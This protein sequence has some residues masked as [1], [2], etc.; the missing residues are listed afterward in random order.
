[1]PWQFK[2]AHTFAISYF[3]WCITIINVSI[4]LYVLA[5]CVCVRARL[6]L[7]SCGF[8]DLN[9]LRLCKY[10]STLAPWY[11]FCS[12][13]IPYRYYYYFHFTSAN[14]TKRKPTR[15]CKKK[16]HSWQLAFRWVSQFNS[17]GISAMREHRNV[18]YKWYFARKLYNR[19]L[20]TIFIIIQILIDVTSSKRI[21]HGS[22]L[23]L[24]QVHAIKRK[25]LQ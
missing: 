16:H 20:N 23:R 22:Q 17:R 3:I 24:N 10:N 2:S 1:M 14:F 5:L 19:R 12:L 15:L 6:C 9:R 8:P 7:R 18:H 11:L 21:S 13:I 4:I 25:A